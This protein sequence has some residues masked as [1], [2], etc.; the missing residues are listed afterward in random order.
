MGKTWLFA[1]AA[2]EDW[3]GAARRGRLASGEVYALPIEHVMAKYLL[4]A[5]SYVFIGPVR[6]ERR[7]GEQIERR[8][9][10]ALELLSS[11]ALLAS[12]PPGREE[13]GA[14]AAAAS[15]EAGMV[16]AIA[17]GS[18]SRLPGMRA[19]F[20]PDEALASLRLPVPFSD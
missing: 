6:F 18:F 15:A 13:A 17:A 10:E 20:F 19:A 11:S 9:G 7:F 8:F 1:P 12:L 5:L 2:L 3:L 14:P 4:L 16:W